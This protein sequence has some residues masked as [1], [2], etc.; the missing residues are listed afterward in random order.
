MKQIFQGLSALFMAVISFL[1]ARIK[2][3]AKRAQYLE[4]SRHK[5]QD[6]WLMK[7]DPEFA[8]IKMDMEKKGGGENGV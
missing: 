4:D 1:T 7:L 2:E 3:L 8:K 6:L 5:Y